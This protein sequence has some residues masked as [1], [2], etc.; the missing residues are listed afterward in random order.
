[1][2]RY[3]CA[4]WAGPCGTQGG[5]PWRKAPLPTEPPHRAPKHLQNRM[6]KVPLP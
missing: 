3:T 6:R 5:Q 1:M 4:G 2:P